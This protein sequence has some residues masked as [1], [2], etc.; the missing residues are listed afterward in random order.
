MGGGA[1]GSLTARA[2]RLVNG[3]LAKNVSAMGRRTYGVPLDGGGSFEDIGADGIGDGWRFVVA[4][5][6]SVG[7]S[8]AI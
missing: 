4:F 5:P 3:G 2:K 7:G 1:I 6:A 8:D